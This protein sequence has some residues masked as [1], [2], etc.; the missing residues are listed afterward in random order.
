[1]CSDECGVVELMAE[2]NVKDKTRVLACVYS[3]VVCSAWNAFEISVKRI[4]GVGVCSRRARLILFH[5]GPGNEKYFTCQ[6]YFHLQHSLGESLSVNIKRQV[7]KT[8]LV[9]FLKT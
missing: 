9:W 1:M 2:A 4:C 5:Y 7:L 6:S 8:P 3:C